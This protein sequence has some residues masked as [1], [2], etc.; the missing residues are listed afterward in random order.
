MELTGRVV[1]KVFAKGSKSERP[2]IYLISDSGEYLLRRRGANPFHDSELEALIGRRI[3]CRGILH[4][5]TFIIASW[6]ILT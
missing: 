1:R 6:K 2:G 5:Y 3:S 4:D